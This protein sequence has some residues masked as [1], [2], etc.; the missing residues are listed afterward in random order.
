MLY[1]TL[2]G[3]TIPLTSDEITELANSAQNQAIDAAGRAARRRVPIEIVANR[4]KDAGLLGNVLTSLGT[5]K[6]IQYLSL[7]YVLPTDAILIAAITSAGG[8]AS[9]ILK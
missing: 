8:N 3:K 5:P 6:T 9:D 2:N 1:K 4:L 7:G